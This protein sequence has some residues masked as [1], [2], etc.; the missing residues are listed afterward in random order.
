MLTLPYNLLPL[1][2]SLQNLLL[3]LLP[4]PP[5]LFPLLFVLCFCRR[6]AIRVGDLESARKDLDFDWARPEL[7]SMIRTTEGHIE[8]DGDLRLAKEA[9][10]V[11][12]RRL[13]RV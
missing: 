3:S 9:F 8:E 10:V 7:L 6:G 1:Y 12:A 5:L 2:S 4:S 11:L 13:L